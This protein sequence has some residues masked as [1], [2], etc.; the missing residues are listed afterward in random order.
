MLTY[1][2]PKKWENKKEIILLQ[3]K[4][5]VSNQSKIMTSISQTLTLCTFAT[6]FLLKK[7]RHLKKFFLKFSNEMSS[8]LANVRSIEGEKKNKLFNWVKLSQFAFVCVYFFK[9][10]LLWVVLGEGHTPLLLKTFCSLFTTPI[11]GAIFDTV[12]QAEQRCLKKKK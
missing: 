10:S 5:V 2:Q 7:A 6:L 1:S 9:K 12:L 11:F 4:R 8:I 3:K